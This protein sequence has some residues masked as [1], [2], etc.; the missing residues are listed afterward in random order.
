MEDAKYGHDD[1]AKNDFPNW[2]MILS[3]INPLYTLF[4]LHVPLIG[5]RLCNVQA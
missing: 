5:D 4:P 2:I 3:A 1:Q